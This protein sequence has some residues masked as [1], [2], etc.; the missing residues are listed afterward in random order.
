MT[1]F[2]HPKHR[3]RALFHGHMIADTGSAVALRRDG[4]PDLFFFPAEDAEME[5]LVETGFTR[6]L[7]GVGMAR[8]FSIY[9]DQSIIE[10]AAWRIEGPEAGCEDLAGLIT[11]D[12]D[13][14][15]LEEGDAENRMWDAQAEKMSDY[16]RHTD[17][18]SGRSQDTPWAPNVGVASENLG[19]DEDD[20]GDEDAFTRGSP[21]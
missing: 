19:E 20:R 11:F 7:P 5:A 8:A 6:A 21:T 3:V 15:Q 13:V 9:R 12:L 16:I 2:T 18:G 4:Q 14:V 10:H 1:E 17:S